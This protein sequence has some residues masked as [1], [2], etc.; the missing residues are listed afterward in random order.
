MDNWCIDIER[1]H[2]TPYAFFNDEMEAT[3]SSAIDPKKPNFRYQNKI[4]YY[5]MAY[6]EYPVLPTLQK[7]II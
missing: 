7:D 4:T 1:M 3:S 2:H 6:S 5:Y